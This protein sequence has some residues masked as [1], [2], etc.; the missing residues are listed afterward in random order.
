M[1]KDLQKNNAA[2]KAYHS[3]ARRAQTKESS[4]P[5]SLAVKNSALGFFWSLPLC[6]LL[7]FISALVAFKAKDPASLTTPLAVASLGLSSAFS[8]FLSGKLNGRSQMLCSAMSGALL[9]MLIMVLSLFMGGSYR[10]EHFSTSN[11]AILYL[12]SFALSLGGGFLSSVKRKVRRK[13]PK[14]R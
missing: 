4:S 14:R 1:K 6:V 7:I 5:F 9:V 12:A 10:G 11:R 8:G 2:P 3:H 13:A